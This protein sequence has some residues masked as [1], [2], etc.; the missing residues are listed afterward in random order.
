M[1]Q[2]LFYFLLCFSF[3]ENDLRLVKLEPVTKKNAFN[4]S[5]NQCVCNLNFFL[6]II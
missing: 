3:V 4:K 6:I 1:S 2:R 5:Q